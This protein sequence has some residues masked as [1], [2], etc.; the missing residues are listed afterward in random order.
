MSSNLF[1]QYIIVVILILA[2]L[3]RIVWSLKKKKKSKGSCCGCSLAQ[4]CGEYRRPWSAPGA[5]GNA[6][7]PPGAHRDCH[8]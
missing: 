1:W 2:A 8:K 6:P 4:A 5:G 3:A 7:A